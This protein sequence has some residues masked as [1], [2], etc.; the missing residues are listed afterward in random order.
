MHHGAQAVQILKSRSRSKVAAGVGEGGQR[1][2]VVL[3][4]QLDA[5]PHG[6]MSVE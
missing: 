2:S 4:L 3:L 6:R 1:W 5:L